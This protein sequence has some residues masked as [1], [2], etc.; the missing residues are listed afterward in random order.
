MPKLYKSKAWLAL[1]RKQGKTIAEI[2]QE[3][4]VSYQ[5]IFN[6]LKEFSIK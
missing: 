5:M 6:Q 3:C 4:G 2:A 1:R